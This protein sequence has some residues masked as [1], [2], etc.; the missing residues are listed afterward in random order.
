M[1]IRTPWVAVVNFAFVVIPG[2]DCVLA[3]ESKT[4]CEKLRMD[5]NP[6]LKGKG[7]GCHGSS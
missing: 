4:L 7:Q 2:V 6:F 1:L 3:L 5:V